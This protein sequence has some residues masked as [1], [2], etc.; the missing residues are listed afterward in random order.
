MLQRQLRTAVRTLRTRGGFVALNLAGLVVGIV[1]SLLIWQY[2]LHAWSYD[3]FHADADRIY[4]VRFDLFR[5]GDRLFKSATTFPAVGPTLADDAPEVEA[6]AR[7]FLRADGGV[8]R[9][10]DRSFKETQVFHAD[11]TFL[12][13]FD[14]PMLRGTRQTALDA[15]GTVVLSQ[16]AAQ[17]YFGDADPVGE[18]IRFGP[19]ET[20]TVTGVVRSPETSHLR[21]DL[22]FSF[23][24]LETLDFAREPLQDYAWNWYDFYTYVRLAPG[25][26]PASLEARLPDVVARHTSE[27]ASARVKLSLQPLPSIHLTSNLIQEARTNG[28]ATTVYVLALIAAFILL[29]AW[30]NDVNLATA[31]A[32]ERAREVGVR[33]ALGA[34]RGQ[35]VRQFVLESFTLNLAAVLVSLAIVRLSLPAF[36]RLVGTPE[37]LPMTSDATFWGLFAVLFVVGSL[38]V[39]L[40][41]AL[42]LAGYD[43]ARVLKGTFARSTDGLLLRRGLVTGQ[44]VASV[45]LIAGTLIVFQQ[46][47]FMQSRDLGVDVDRVL[48]VEA[49]DLLRPDSLYGGQ[50]R[51]FTQELERLAAVDH[52][53]ASTE[54]PGHLIYWT[55]GMRRRGAPAESSTILYMVGIGEGYLDTYGHKI[56]AGRA[57]RPDAVADSSRVLLTQ[58]AV[59]ALGFDSPDAAVGAF[60]VGGPDTL[61][62]AGVVVDYHQEGL[63]RPVE[64]VGFRLR[65]STQAYQYV[66]LRLRSDD[67]T[68]ALASVESTFERFFPGDPFAYTVL[69]DAFDQQ[70][71]TY[72]R[73]GRVFALF[74]GLAIFVACLGLLG[75]SAFIATQRTK[76]IGIRKVLGASVTHV[77]ALLSKDFLRLVLVGAAVAVPVVWWGMQR[78]LNGFAYR[79]EIRGL[80]FL[81][82]TAL[83]LVVALAT[84]GTQALR[85]ARLDP[86]T[87]LRSE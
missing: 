18:T 82:A 13:V 7:L 87:T 14:Y 64:P 21:F 19:D 50:M 9:V 44:F 58:T 1:A 46:I 39:G 38:V 31:R 74:A 63:H 78:W 67:W 72:R 36:S 65:Q 32:T 56:V 4:R 85:A 6:Y 15:P 3:D 2:V 10:G 81:V 25:A 42:V 66:S 49:P 45:G 28:D 80:A 75:L 20:Y 12:T 51:S 83:V 48:V 57:L 79:I 47:D 17:R 55:S 24:T 26:D 8:V 54:V 53:A 41:P 22:L 27:Q 23:A 43:P 30:V 11:S 73:F 33:K 59:R 71:R 62:V 61:E 40:Y 29:I 52:A 37:P 60:V 16:R 77:V 68:A 76:E 70:Y 86:A 5:E 84:V 69:D 35:L 34:S